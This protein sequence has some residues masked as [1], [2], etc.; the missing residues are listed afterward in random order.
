MS[1]TIQEVLE[2]TPDY[3]KGNALRHK[4]SE[5]L[6]IGVL[7]ILCNGSG[8][9][10][11]KLFGDMHEG[12][13]REFLELP[14]GIPSQ[15]T[16]ERVFAKLNPRALA[17]Q[18]KHWVDDI[19]NDLK[20]HIHVSI[21]GKTAR[22]SKSADKKALHVVTAFAS[23][24]KLVLGQLATDEKS[25]EITAIP[26][27]LE[28]FCTSGMI[29]TID[30]MGTQTEIARKIIGLGGDYVLALKGNQQ[31]LLEDVRLFLEKEVISQDKK[32]LRKNGQY[33]KTIEKGHGRIETR[34]CFISQG[35]I[36]GLDP[37]HNWE[38]LSKVGVI[39]SKRELLGKAP[40]SSERFFI[41]S[42]EQANA[43]DLLR[44]VRS[45]WAIE[46]NLHWALDVIL[47]EDASRA[48]LE[49]A[50]ENLNIIRKQ[51]LQFLRSETSVIGSIESKRLRCSWDIS[52][53]LKVIGVK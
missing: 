2:E 43:A 38:G 24:L 46:N 51:V 52:Y 37:E 35:D 6:L 26:K 15:D 11:M 41:T 27:L 31:T 40:E 53:A 3:R 5:I 9:A 13:L 19:I 4:L 17:G 33:E 44:A 28:M 12:V 50:Q 36:G 34:E 21:D 10:A 32:D 16:F 47:G 23:E 22:G 20:G 30:A 42:L 14:H 7:T 45:H 39:R 48:R 18:F 25:N 29:I 1:K 8:F 49:N